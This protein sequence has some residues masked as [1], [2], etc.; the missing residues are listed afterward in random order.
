MVTGNIVRGAGE[1]YQNIASSESRLFEYDVF[2]LSTCA[3]P[4]SEKYKSK[5]CNSSNLGKY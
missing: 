1:L 3:E 5:V 4:P 2:E